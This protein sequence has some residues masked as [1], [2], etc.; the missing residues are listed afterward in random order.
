MSIDQIEVRLTKKSHLIGQKLKG[1]TIL[2]K[3]PHRFKKDPIAFAYEVLGREHPGENR[4]EW[5]AEVV[6]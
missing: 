3:V 5:N 2:V 1:S 4:M 6:E